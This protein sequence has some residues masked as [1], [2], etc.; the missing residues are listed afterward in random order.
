M[1]RAPAP[2]AAGPGAAARMVTVLLTEGLNGLPGLAETALSLG[3]RQVAGLSQPERDL[4]ACVPTAHVGREP[5]GAGR[6]L[7][8]LAGRIAA[9]EDP[10]GEALC[11]IRGAAERRGLGQTLTPVPVV[12]SM[13]EWAA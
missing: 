10:L 4:A 5:A 13:I 9:G 12:T 7:A 11:A 2:P 6:E 1:R 8:E 3:A